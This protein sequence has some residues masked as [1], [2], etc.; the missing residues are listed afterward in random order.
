M[1][2]PEA[3]ETRDEYMSRCMVYGDLQKY[4]E[5]QRAAI[6]EH[7]YDREATVG[8][9]EERSE[10]FSLSADAD[11]IDRESG[12]LRGVKIMGSRSKHGY[13]FE[14]SAIAANRSRFEGMAVGLDHDYKAG[15]LTIDHTW[16]TLR[17]VDATG[18]RGDLHFNKSHPRTEQILENIEREIGPV[19]LS[20]VYEQFTEENRSGR[21]VVTSFV[22]KRIDVV[23]GGATTR[24]MFEQ[25]DTDPLRKELDEVKAELKKVNATMSRFE[26]L[27][28]RQ[29]QL[30]HVIDSTLERATNG[31]AIDLKKFWND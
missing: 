7:L 20:P 31:G 8:E 6:C 30:K 18:S 23:V 12:V 2:K 15:P 22:A 29:E 26:Q 19:S 3:G 16:G 11:K 25:A 10:Q 4:D 27:A 14:S 17:D 24:T 13:D 9:H 28:Q 1:P 21:R 5:K